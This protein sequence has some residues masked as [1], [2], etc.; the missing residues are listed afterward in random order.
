MK[1]R[2]LSCIIF[3]LANF[4]LPKYVHA[5]DTYFSTGQPISNGNPTL[6]KGIDYYKQSD[7]ENAVKIIKPLADQ[8]DPTAQYDLAMIYE[9]GE[10]SSDAANTYVDYCHK[11]AEQN[12]APAERCLGLYHYETD[13]NYNMAFYWIKKSAEQGDS[14]AQTW[15]A[16]F[17]DMAGDEVKAAQW[18]AKAA[19]QGDP[20]GQTALGEAYMQGKGIPINYHKGVNLFT[21]VINN[22]AVAYNYEDVYDLAQAYELG[23]GVT[24]N[25]VTAY[26]LYQLAAPDDNDAYQAYIKLKQSKLLTPDQ[27]KQVDTIIQTY[28]ANGETSPSLPDL[29]QQVAE[30]K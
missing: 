25:Y 8:G 17:Y 2:L 27:F 18:N 20:D 19:A 6:Q 26:F 24:Q 29:I 3:L 13:H 9:Y 23:H 16:T 22:D 1:T 14:Q 7:I 5:N 15:L 21:Q 12:F 11:A 30:I 10:P 28:E 4:C